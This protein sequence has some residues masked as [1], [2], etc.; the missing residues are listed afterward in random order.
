GGGAR[1]TRSQ[2]RD[3]PRRG[4]DLRYILEVDLKDVLTGTQKNIEFTCDQN[5]STCSGTGAKPGTQPISCS[6]C[7]GSGQVVRSQGFFSIATTCPHCQGEGTT[8]KEK[9]SDCR[10]RGRVQVERRLK[11]NVPMGVD[12]GTQLRLS[13]EGEG[14]YRGGEN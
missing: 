7:G 1:S 2:R 5:C 10:G 3:R 11:I 6:T 13:N 8:I 4:S 12:N 14:G 9:C